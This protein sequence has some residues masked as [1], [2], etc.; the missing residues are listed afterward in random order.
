MQRVVICDV[1]G[2]VSPVH[3]HTAWEDDV[4]AGNVFGPVHVSPTLCARLDELAQMPTVTCWWLTSWTAEMRADMSPFPG[5]DW[6]V[7]GEPPPSPSGRRWW[8]L[9]AVEGWLASHPGVRALAWCED[10]LA[11]GARRA[12]V[13]RR[14]RASGLDFLPIAPDTAVGLSPEH[15]VTLR[16]WARPGSS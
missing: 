7:I 15:L 13:S 5:A 14:L 8:K 1:D 4:V 11:N 3:G 2:V 16:Q 10:E 12:A 6:P 9:A